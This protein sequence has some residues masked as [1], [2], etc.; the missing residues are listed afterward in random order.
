[1]SDI[2]IPNKLTVRDFEKCFGRPVSD[3]VRRQIDKYDF[4]YFDIDD[5]EYQRLVIF[6]INSL[7]KDLKE[8]GSH[9]QEEWQQGW[10]ENW[11]SFKKS[12]DLND[13]FPRYYT[14]EKDMLL[15]FDGK[16]IRP[17]S[18]K[19]E[20]NT[21]N[22]IISHVADL[23]MRDVSTIYDFGCGTGKNFLPISAV[24]PNAQLVGADWTQASGKIISKLSKT[25]EIKCKFSLFDFFN[26]DKDLKIQP[27]SAVITVAALEQVGKNFD[28][29]LNYLIESKPEI[30]IHVEPIVE[31]LDPDNNILD[32]CMYHYM[33][34]RNY[35]N[36]LYERLKNL[37]K[38][39][40]IEIISAN[41]VGLGGFWTE[42]TSIIAWKVK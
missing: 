38:D 23:F 6:C 14:R 17:K 33:N 20:L 13:L 24:N 2:K 8:C 41:R 28:K 9:R 18:L 11:N 5:E 35:L 4:S 16:L 19:F 26:P 27:N 34:K 36:G 25:S 12:E 3:Y 22:V 31:F 10:N 29:F 7:K 15:R 40:I 21:H 30:C 39:G 37:E 1:M 42:G 32:Y